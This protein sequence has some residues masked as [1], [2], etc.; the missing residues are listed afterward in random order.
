MI[1]YMYYVLE[2]YGSNP[3]ITALINNTEM[4]FIPCVNPDG[5]VYNETTDPTGGGMWRK[6]RRNNNNATFGIDL[7]RNYGF[8]WAYDNVGSSPTT[9]DETYRGPSAFSEPETQAIKW[10][11]EHHQIKMAINYH[12]F[13]N[14]LIYPW[15]YIA[16]LYTAD[17]SVF[18]NH[19]RLMTSHNHFIAGTGNQTV[20]YVTNGDSD[21]WGYGEQNTKPKILSMTPEVGDPNEGFWP[22]QSSI[23]TIC[24]NSLWQNIYGA[25]LIGKYAY[26]TDFSPSTIANLNGY[27]K[28]TV[29][30]LGLDSTGVYTVSIVPLD[31]LISTVGNPKTYT[32]MSL[33]ET[34]MDSISYTLSPSIAVGQSFRYII[35]VNN[36]WY[37]SNDTITKIFGQP[38]VL[39][40]SN[41]SSVAG[42]TSL[43]G[44]WGV[45]STQYV[46]APGSVTDSP[47][48]NYADNSTKSITLDSTI[49]LTNAI[50]ASLNFWGKW[51]IEQGYDY[52]QVLAS[53]NGG[54]WLPL[55]GNY[56]KPGNQNQDPGNPLYDGFQSA[57]VW[58]TIDLSDYLGAVIKIRFTMVIDQ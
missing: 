31:N 29:Q 14:D 21:D 1:Y 44:N 57:W 55:C 25:E 8:N 3:E 28:Y 37:D 54:G 49:D 47:I 6:N 40:T 56:T 20:Q 34:R 7:N 22:P 15:G 4:Y 45:S 52:V 39:Y 16:D 41:C 30:R 32:N 11:D 18:E 17:S 26:P 35:R 19:T 48:G 5:Y 2:N 33:L 42:F 27:F 13:G 9:N 36:G 50:A 24:E 53:S 43:G 58:E 46:S 10:F 51:A 38:V 12:T 23:L